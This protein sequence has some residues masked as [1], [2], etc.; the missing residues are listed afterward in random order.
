MNCKQWSAAV[1]VL[2]MLAGLAVSAAAQNANPGAETKKPRMYCYVALWTLPRS[3]WGEW[4]KTEAADQKTLQ[5]AMAAGT[6]V[7][8]GDDVNLVHMPDQPTHDDWFC[9]MSEAG[10]INTLEQFYKSGTTASPVLESATKH[11]DEII[12]SQYY[13]HHSGSWKGV[14][15]HGSS[16]KLKE[17]AP[18]DAVDML[19]KSVLVPMM[20]KLLANGTIHEYEIDEAAIHTEAPGTFD[21]FYIAANADALDKVN[22]ALRDALSG[23][24]LIGPTFG[25]MV[26]FKAHRDYLMRSNVT[27]K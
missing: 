23:N 21:V 18:E 1:L 12:V 9:S 26:D 22:A 11:W 10:V 4:D 8:Y 13:N 7:G 19:A 17:D 6:L 2:G 24:P 5:D 25:S 14:Y 20:E 16:Y 15:T 27:Y 3:Q